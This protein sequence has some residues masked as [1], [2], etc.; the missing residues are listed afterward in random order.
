MSMTRSQ[1]AGLYQF[2]NEALEELKTGKRFGNASTLHKDDF[3]AMSDDVVQIRKHESIGVQDL[4]NAGLTRSVNLSDTLVQYYDMNDF[5]AQVSMNGS[6]RINN[7]SDYVP[8]YV[9]Q[10]IY[11]AA[12]HIPF[13]QEGFSYKNADGNREA[14]IA[15]TRKRDEVVFVGNSNVIVNYE[16]TDQPLYGYI[17]HPQTNAGPTLSDW[18]VST[19]YDNIYK[20]VLEMVGVLYDT[21]KTVMPNQ[22]VLYVSTNFWT[23]LQADYST[24]KGDKTVLERILAM[25]EIGAVKPVPYLPASSALLVQMSSDTVQWAESMDVTSVAHQ[26]IQAYEDQ[27]FTTM[28]AGALLIK[29]DRNGVTGIVYS[30]TA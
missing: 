25:A 1:L 12:W 28:A 20:E 26:R 21:G 16:G 13:R 29:T 18:T 6:N 24:Q 11:D 27:Q 9:P 5:S 30:T 7:Q 22:A 4:K 10:P 2:R 15:V 23:S 19:N 3:V 14:I 17:N 8:K